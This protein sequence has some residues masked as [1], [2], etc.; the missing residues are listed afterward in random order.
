MPD[1]IVTDRAMEEAANIA[2][3]I[4]LDNLEASLDVFKAIE[5]A[6]DLLAENPGIGASC[7]IDEDPFRDFRFWPVKKYKVYLVIYRPI[8][9]GVEIVRVIHGAQDMGRVLR[10]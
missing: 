7:E 3:R 10:K 4:G 6:F 2:Y 8:P 9:N 1:L 5:K